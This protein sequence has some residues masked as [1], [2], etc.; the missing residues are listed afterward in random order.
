[1]AS[2]GLFCFMEKTPQAGRMV[3]YKPYKHWSDKNSLKTMELHTKWPILAI[4]E[5]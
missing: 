2:L 5:T 4:K 3:G 1:M